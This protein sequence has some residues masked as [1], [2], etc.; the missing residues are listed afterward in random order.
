MTQNELKT[1]LQGICKDYYTITEILFYTNEHSQL[2]VVIF[3]FNNR[4]EAD[5]RSMSFDK[6]QGAINFFDATDRITMGNA[7][8]AEVSQPTLSLS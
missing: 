2:I 7:P 3:T 8:L 4:D 1:T 6:I 5:L